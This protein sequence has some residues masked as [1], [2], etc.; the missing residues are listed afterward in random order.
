M[1]KVMIVDDEPIILSGIKFLLDWEKNGCVISATAR[2][3]Q[4]ALEQIRKAPPDIV[5]ADINMPVMNGIS[6]LKQVHEEFPYIVFIM[7][8]NLEEF[9]L[10]RE[11]L[12]YQAVDYLLKSELEPEK[13][14]EALG[15]AKQ[16]RERR[17]K[18]VVV[19]S[20]DYFDAREREALINRALQELIFLGGG[21]TS[22]HALDVLMREGMLD[23]YAWVYI[24]CSYA[25]L[26]DAEHM[27]AAGRRELL[28]WI[29][30]L[31]TKT[32][33]TVFRKQYL[34]VDTNQAD[35]LTLFVYGLDSQ[36]EKSMEIFRKKLASTVHTITQAS[37]T[38]M[39][40]DCFSGRTK[41]QTSS[42][43]YQALVDS[44]YLEVPPAKDGVRCFEALGLNGIGVSL[45]TEIKRHSLTDV[46]AILDKACARLS[47]VEHQK[48][49]AIWLLNELNRAASQAFAELG[50]GA[51]ESSE[52]GV[53]TGRVSTQAEIEAVKTRS[54][55]LAWIE[56][57]REMCTDMLKDS[58]GP[59]SQLAERARRYVLEHLE[60]H[61]S[62]RDA[63]DYVGVSVGYLSTVFKK[64]HGQSFVDF[65]NQAK[66]EYACKLLDDRR[67]MVAEIACRL[68][69]ENAYYFSK[70]FRKYRNMTPTEYQ[71]R[72]L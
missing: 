51:L 52:D 53:Q 68:G 31:T 9:S 65:M 20:G 13:L 14:E 34:F 3:G 70:V 44:Y 25:E 21:E 11:A 45:A 40:T 72:K 71:K 47:A 54:Q 63:A 10:A 38:P 36:W 7:L 30:E 55:A 5:L 22:A 50:T 16:E 18:L 1:Y 19:D 59:G 24:P 4:D 2:N 69:F 32:A 8:T 60:E 6:L 28:L 43:A 35:V 26:P 42:R 67:L 29:Q 27:T 12:V 39:A 56:R 48:S 61:V 57:L 62:L 46:Q 66:I 41:L 33:D 37:C 15:F 17:A 49:Q 58:G 64:E 23:N